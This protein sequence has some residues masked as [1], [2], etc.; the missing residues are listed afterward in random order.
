MMSKQQLCARESVIVAFSLCAVLVAGPPARGAEP[1]AVSNAWVRTPAPGQKVAGAYMELVSGSDS[2]L[3][4]VDSPAA[5]RVE[6]HT[7]KLDAGVMKMRQVERI[8]LPAKQA[9]KLAPGGMHIMLVDLRR[10]LKEGDTVPLTLTIRHAGAPTQVKVEA[11][12]RAAPGT[13]QH[14]H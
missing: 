8:D 3:V 6:L 12:V 11:T 10:P 14:R 1:V 7:M 5:A 9:V 4:G 2:A 13:S